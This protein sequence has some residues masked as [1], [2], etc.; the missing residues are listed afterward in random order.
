MFQAG[1]HHWIAVQHGE[2]GGGFQRSNKPFA[3]QWLLTE[4]FG[5]LG[6]HNETSGMGIIG[7]IEVHGFLPS[8]EPLGGIGLRLHEAANELGSKGAIDEQLMY[9][10]LMHRFITVWHKAETMS[11]FFQEPELLVEE[12]GIVDHKIVFQIK[13][14]IRR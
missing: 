10:R 6:T 2:G 8:V 11:R 12:S 5:L 13:I 4:L 3:R 7:E 1:F 14:E 9:P